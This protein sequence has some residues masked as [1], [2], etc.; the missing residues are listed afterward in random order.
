MRRD[1]WDDGPPPP[2]PTWAALVSIC[3][4]VWVLLAGVV[5]V[6]VR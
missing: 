1:D 4:V 3:L 5:S 2:A 6:V